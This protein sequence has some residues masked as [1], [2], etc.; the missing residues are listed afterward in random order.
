MSR[1]TGPTS[2]SQRLVDPGLDRTFWSMAADLDHDDLIDLMAV[3]YEPVPT[4]NLTALRVHSYL[5]AGPNGPANCAW[6]ESPA[7]PAGCAF[8]RQEAIDLSTWAAGQWVARFS[9]DAVDVTGDGNRDLTVVTHSNGGNGPSKVTVLAGQGD[10]TF[11]LAAGELFQFNSPGGIGDSPVNAIAFGDFNGDDLGDVVLGM[12]DDGDAG[13]AWFVPGMLG[14]QGFDFD[15]AGAFEAFDVNPSAES[16]GDNMGVSFNLRAFDWDFDGNDD[17]L[18]GYKHQAAWTGGSRAVYLRGL[19][20]GD[21][22]PPVTIDEDATTS[23]AQN[24]AAPYRL[25][26][27]FPLGN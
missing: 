17:L 21:F 9:R 15:E 4:G 22:E 25:C 26:Q 19:G 20:N 6:T 27:R 12:D 14:P 13:S 24:F 3:E 8:V 1:I 2:L 7:N 10:G 18:M 16:G 5:N 11:Q 23:R